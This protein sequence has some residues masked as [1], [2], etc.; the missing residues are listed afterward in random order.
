MSHT[1][2]H[3]PAGEALDALL[4]AAAPEPLVD[5]GFVAHTMVAVDQ[6]TRSL[7]VRRPAPVA[8]VAIARALAAEQR[9]HA[10]QARLWRWAIAGVA[11]GFVLLA[12]A[13]VFSPGKVTID[14]PSPLQWFPLTALL[15]IGAIWV[16]W[17]EL[18]RA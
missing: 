18:R 13:V 10:A 15:A 4:R 5:D 11:A 9:R 16:A 3:D 8:P 6:A 7:P 14:M 12:F 2:E 1:P 17:R